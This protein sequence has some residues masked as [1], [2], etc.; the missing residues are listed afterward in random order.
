MS[1]NQGEN[2]LDHQGIMESISD[3]FI[4][5]PNGKIAY[6]PYDF[7]TA[8]SRIIESVP[9][10]G[11]IQRFFLEQDG[12]YPF[13]LSGPT[14]TK[15]IEWNLSENEHR[16]QA[17]VSQM[18]E[19]PETGYFLDLRRITLN[20]LEMFRP[21]GV[22]SLAP[23]QPVQHERATIQGGYHLVPE[24]KLDQLKQVP[25][26]DNLYIAFY[27]NPDQSRTVD[28]FYS[29][30]VSYISASE[31]DDCEYKADAPRF[32]AYSVDDI[33][34]DIANTKN[35]L[36][37]YY[38]DTRVQSGALNPIDI[39]IIRPYSP[40]GAACYIANLQTFQDKTN[41]SK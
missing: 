32:K 27:Q 1:N 28:E 7:Y 9:V 23:D 40:V 41:Q 36:K 12:K 4:L 6:L 16:N 30:C 8:P 19:K 34:D 17:I 24:D 10:E 35:H 37:H 13:N 5:R 14:V 15:V 18:K 38:G 31:L 21:L 39:D 33:V 26:N 20:R 22:N 11:D 3:V 2:K 25:E 29:Y